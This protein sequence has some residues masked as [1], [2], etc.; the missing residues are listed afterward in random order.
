MDLDLQTDQLW[1]SP[2]VVILRAQTRTFRVFVDILKGKSTVFADMFTFPQPPSSDMETIDGVPVVDLHD[3]AADLEVFLKAMFDSEFFMAHFSGT[4]FENTL[5]ILRLAHKYDVPFLRRRALQHL[6]VIYPTQLSEYD[7]PPRIENAEQKIDLRIA[8]ILTATEVGAL[9][10]LPA[11]YYRL[12]SIAT[13]TILEDPKWLLL[14]EKERNACLLGQWAQN[15]QF[16]TIL[17]F[18]FV[19]SENCEDAETCNER[20]LVLARHYYSSSLSHSDPLAYVSKAKWGSIT[21]GLCGNCVEAC[22]PLHD[23]ARQKC[24]DA[25]PECFGLPTWE[26]LEGMREAALST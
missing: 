9:W 20:R 10:V 3:N 14:G 19:P 7:C 18:L 22:R 1:F 23:A 17:D 4:K 21:G 2:D 12:C 24:W 5:G 8:T 15:R 13:S 11:A 6:G 16:S 25:L 26:I